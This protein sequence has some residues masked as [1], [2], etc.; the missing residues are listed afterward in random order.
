MRTSD[1]ERMEFETQLFFDKNSDG[2]SFLVLL[3]G[4]CVNCCLVEKKKPPKRTKH[5]S[6]RLVMSVGR[7][8][9]MQCNP[10]QPTAFP[11]GGRQGSGVETENSQMNQKQM[12]KVRTQYSI[13]NSQQRVREYYY[14][15]PLVVCV[16]LG[17]SSTRNVILPFRSAAFDR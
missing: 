10:I 15:I 16:L 1:V 5:K 14:L 17:T 7:R 11:N 3:F 2:M 8:R 6:Y 9:R 12:K 4:I 13:F